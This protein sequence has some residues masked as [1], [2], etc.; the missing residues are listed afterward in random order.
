MA[1]THYSLKL[2]LLSPLHIGYRKVGNLM[3]TRPYVPGKVLWAALTARLTRMA[4]KGADGQAYQDT[5]AAISQHFRFGYLWPSLDGT[6]SYWPWKHKDF[7]YLLLNSYPSTALN[8]DH[9]SA[10]EGSL[11]ETEFIAPVAR[12]RRD[13]YLVG[14]LWVREDGLPA[15]LNGWQ[16]AFQKLQLGGERTYGWGRVQ[17]R[18][19][20]SSGQNGSGTTLVGHAWREQNGEVVLM[21][22][23]DKDERLTAHALAV[24]GKAVSG[25]VGPV[26]PLVGW[27]RDNEN[28]GRTWRLS[29]ALI[30]WEPGSWVSEAITAQV[31]PFGI[32]EA[33]SP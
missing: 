21:P 9:Q 12:D 32:W 2:R 17:C 5:G 25:I 11:H 6:S 10:E 13:V 7:D 33:V 30:C 16:E 8:Y 3:Q 28:P 27:E 15:V 19:D 20:W 24:G 26:E 22:G 31:G 23:A 4:G 29:T 18:S 1:W 14:D